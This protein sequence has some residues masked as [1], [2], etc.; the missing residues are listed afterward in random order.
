MS[1]SEIAK[2]LPWW[3]KWVAVPVLAIVVF[4][5]MIMSLIGFIVALVFKVLLFA[6]LVAGLIFVVRKFT[7]SSSSRDSSRSEW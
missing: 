2:G 3:V 7:G 5:G 6:V 4:G 1:V